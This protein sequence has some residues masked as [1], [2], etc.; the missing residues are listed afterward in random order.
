[1]TYDN[2][3]Y[4]ISDGHIWNVSWILQVQIKQKYQ[5]KNL[6][7]AILSTISPTCTGQQLTARA[8]ADSVST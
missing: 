3:V 1:M 8:I 7:S 2:A 4:S 5:E 6:P